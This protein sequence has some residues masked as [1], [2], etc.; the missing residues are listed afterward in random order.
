MFAKDAPDQNAELGLHILPHGPVDVD[1]VAD[2]RNQLPGYVAE[3]VV[4]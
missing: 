4:A 1:I 3:G 2:C